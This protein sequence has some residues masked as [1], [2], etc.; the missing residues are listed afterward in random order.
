M[1]IILA[2]LARVSFKDWAY[3]IAFV[4]LAW[5]GLHYYHK[6]TAAVSYAQQ[7]K[8]ESDATKAK[9]A[10][11]LAAKDAS[12]NEALADI[13]GRK[14]AEIKVAVA[15]SDDLSARLRAYTAAHNCPNTVLQGAPTAPAG[16]SVPA[17]GSDGVEA[18]IER[19]IAAAY[20]D[21]AVVEAERA[22]RDAL[23]GK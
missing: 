4:V 21:T 9:A 23:T 2:L 11:D 10:A 18:A 8:T 22:E 13:I 3:S 15:N 14:N 7:L 6:Y 12:Y 16:A 20:H 17:S 1:S 5:T 19:V